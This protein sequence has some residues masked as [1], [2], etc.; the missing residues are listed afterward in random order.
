[1]TYINDIEAI[2]YLAAGY[3]GS[4]IIYNGGFIAIQADEEIIPADIASTQA[5]QISID[6]DKDEKRIVV[7]AGVVSEIE[8]IKEQGLPSSIQDLAGRKLQK[9][10]TQG[11]YI[12]NG[13]KHLYK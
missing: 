3:T 10:Q 9:I 8:G 2:S 11:I 4:H 6:V 5:E 7:S 13:K 1:M 12:V